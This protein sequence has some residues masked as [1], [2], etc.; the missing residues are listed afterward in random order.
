M[1]TAL[2]YDTETTG[3]PL[4]KEPSN[5]PDQPHIVQLAAFLVD[6]DTRVTLASMD[7]IIR[8]DGWTIPDDMTAIHGISTQKALALGIPEAQAVEMLLA[9]RQNATVRIAHNEPFDARIARIGIK[10]FIDPRDPGLVIP[11]SDDWKASNAE[12]TARLATPICK[13]PP[14]AKMRGGNKT[15]TLLEAYQHFFGQEFS[16]QHTARGDALACMRVYFAIQDLNK[17]Q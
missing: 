17:G 1:N 12:C 10:R 13:L 15:P 8:P 9:L 16:G 11:E 5:H 14:T 7:V 2:F 6:L 3:L 4:F